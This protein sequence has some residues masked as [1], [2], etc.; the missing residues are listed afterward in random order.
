MFIL[1]YVS[2]LLCGVVW[3]IDYKKINL[4]QDMK[5]L[6]KIMERYNLLRFRYFITVEIV[7]NLDVRY[8]KIEDSLVIT[9]AYS[10]TTEDMSRCLQNADI[11]ITK[12]KIKLHFDYEGARNYIKEFSDREYSSTNINENFNEWLENKLILVFDKMNSYCLD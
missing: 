4:D 3:M 2:I 7:K 6:K 11:H 12:N 8:Y 1:S 5:K 9:N 10:D